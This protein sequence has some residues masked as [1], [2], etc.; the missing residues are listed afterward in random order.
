[1]KADQVLTTTELEGLL[2]SHP[3]VKD[4]AVIGVY[5]KELA[6]ELP[7]AYVVL[8][9]GVDKSQETADEIQQWL[10]QRVAKHKRLRGGVQFI[11]TIPSSATGKILRRELKVLAGKEGE[12]KSKL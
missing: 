4:A 8:D 9:A 5:S 6:T 2:T 3:R 10:S 11:D 7:R 1:M 12:V